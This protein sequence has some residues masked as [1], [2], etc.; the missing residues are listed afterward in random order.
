MWRRRVAGLFRD[1]EASNKWPETTPLTPGTAELWVNPSARRHRGPPEDL[2]S[3][4]SGSPGT[5]QGLQMTEEFTQRNTK[6]CQV[7]V[8]SEMG[9]GEE[10]GGQRRQG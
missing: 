7:V 10:C 4:M 8:M 9:V 2:Q 6:Y 1:T 3:Y 5:L